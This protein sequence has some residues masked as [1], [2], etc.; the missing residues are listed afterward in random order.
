MLG[1]FEQD[2]GRV[3]EAPD[4]ARLAAA[5]TAA[6][7]CRLCIDALLGTGF[8]RAPEGLM[9]AAIDWLNNQPA[10][11]VAVDLPSGVDASSGGIPGVAVRAALTVTFAFPKVGLVS[12]PGAGCAG[13]VLT[14]PIGIPELIAAAAPDDG[15]LVDADEARLLLPSRPADGHKGTFGHLLVMAGS[16]GKSGAA[17]MT[18][19]AGLR[20]G[21]GLV[22]LACPAGMQAVAAAH[23]VEV[24]TAPLTEV[25]GAVSLQAMEQ[26]LALS[27][28]KQAVAL[29]PGLG[30][31]E[32]VGALVRRYLKET[33]LPAV[34]DADG[35]NALVG[36]L[37]LLLK[38]RDRA[39][40]LTPHPGEMARLSGRTPAEI[41]ADRIGVSRAFAVDHGVVLVLKGARTITALPDGRVRINGSGHAGM[42]SGGMGDVLTGLIGGLLAQ[43]MDPGAAATLGVFLHGL[44]GDRLRV[45][46]GDAGMLATDL[47]REIPAARHSLTI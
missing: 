10:P 6:A 40:V 2:G 39:T 36:H 37:D 34:V 28:G 29:G 33:T 45:R 1:R 21:A 46:Y 15:L 25:D 35:L 12:Y 17:V 24:M 7:G 8:A 26:L 5:L 43:G 44:A 16:L 38:R 32:E 9:A 22:T 4:D 3:C 18:S 13:E 42:A 41:Q 27:D 14:V 23:L 30:T 20:A 19:E 47:L 11:V 31:G